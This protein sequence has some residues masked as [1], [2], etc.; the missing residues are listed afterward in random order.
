MIRSFRPSDEDDLIGV[1]LTSTISGQAF[2]PEAHWR[3]MEEEVRHELLPAARTW[4]VLDDGELVAFMSVLDGTIGGLF[5]HPDHQGRG[6]GKAL[7]EVARRSFDPLSVEV[8]KANER[9]LRFYRRCGFVDHERREDP[10]SGLPL[11][12]LR[13]AR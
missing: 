8:F 4:V 6:H 12:I 13:M 3:A 2:L 11:L 7:V 10:D 5:T 9:A 1:W